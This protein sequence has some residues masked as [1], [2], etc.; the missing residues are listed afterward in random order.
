MPLN[1]PGKCTPHWAV[2]LLVWPVWQFLVTLSQRDLRSK[3]IDT[4]CA[5]T[6]DPC[7]KLGV[8]NE[9]AFH[10]CEPSS[11]RIEILS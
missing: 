2:S 4:R 5:P 6:S 8:F 9:A 11:H 7:R 10:G 1:R 3:S